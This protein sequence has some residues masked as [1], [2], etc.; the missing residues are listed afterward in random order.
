LIAVPKE[1][2]CDICNPK[3]FDSARP[4][5]SVKG[6]RQQG[7]RR[8][9][10]VDSVR[11]ELFSWR[12]TMKKQH[13]PYA[14]FAPHALL[15]DATCEVLASIGPLEDIATLKQLLGTSWY[16]WD[17][18]GDSLFTLMR[19]LDIA[20]LPPPPPRAKKA[21]APAQ[22]A[23]TAIS[24]APHTPLAP[25][26]PPR[27]SG[28]AAP[29][30]THTTH[31]TPLDAAAPPA[32]RAR[33]GIISETPPTPAVPHPRWRLTHNGQ[34]LL[35][36]PPYPP[37]APLLSYPPYPPPAP[38]SPSSFATPARSSP[39]TLTHALYTPAF[40]SSAYPPQPPYAPP[41]PGWYGSNP[42]YSSPAMAP[43]APSLGISPNLAGNPYARLIYPRSIHPDSSVAPTSQNSR[44]A[45]PSGAPAQPHIQPDSDT[46]PNPR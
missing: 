9:P 16:R 36:Y 28:S 17:E 42:H 12:R 1:T 11:Q 41:F 23:P 13:Y 40:H 3:L 22:K 2:C 8:G 6:T 25:Q 27:A 20:P 35:S 18:L 21:T 14:V 30:R 39:V 10:A 7:I 26:S 31:S 24:N 19:S 29:K 5:K 43:A 38:H 33:V 46:P 34:P 44:E 4:G 45:G 15:D 32:Q 37:L